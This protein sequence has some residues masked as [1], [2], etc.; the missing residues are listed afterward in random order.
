MTTIIES[1]AGRY[2]WHENWATIPASENGRTHG[3]GV[4]RDGRV[5]VFHQAVPGVLVFTHEGQLVDSWGNYPGA[6]GLTV[7]EEGDE[8]F[9]WLV[10]QDRAVAEKTTLK[11]D[12]VQSLPKPPHT[13][14]ATA[15]YVPT[16]AVV[17]ELRFGGNGDIWLADGYGASLVHRYDASGNYL[18][19]I[20]GTEGAGR[21]ACPHGIWFD[22]RKRPAELYIADRGNKRVQVYDAEG[23]FLRSFGTDFLTSP[24]G[25]APVGD[26][27]I[28]PELCA[29]VSILD[30]ADKLVDIL[31]ENDA[32]C[33]APGWPNETPLSE[34]KFNSPHGAVANSRGDIFVVEWRVGGRI[35]KLEKL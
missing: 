10:D 13:V 20:D 9:L 5:F 29:R 17:N 16:W 27:L 32:I 4:T 23:K 18:S 14:Y 24:D 28:V 30:A 21:F 22:S 31:G 26:H 19:T 1:K 2:Q 34:G 7:V 35:I 15:N 11:G 12:V 25:F 3:L 6:H 8:E 33:A